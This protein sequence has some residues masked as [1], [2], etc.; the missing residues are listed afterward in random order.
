MSLKLTLTGPWLPHSQVEQWF[1][2]VGAPSLQPLDARL[3][4]LKVS[5]EYKHELSSLI[6][7]C[8]D[9]R[10]AA[11]RWSSRLRLSATLSGNGLQS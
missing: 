3:T 6:C 5:L 7:H 1:L 8:E 2:R 4:T 11:V 10:A 9:K